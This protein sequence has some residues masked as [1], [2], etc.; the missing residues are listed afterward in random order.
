MN[1]QLANPAPPPPHYVGVVAGTRGPFNNPAMTVSP[2][3]RLQPLHPFTPGGASALYSSH[4]TPLIQGEPQPLLQP[5]HPLTPGE[6][7]PYTPATT[8]LYSRGSPSP[9]LQGEPQPFTPGGAPALIYSGG[10]PSPILQPQHPFTPGGSPALYSSHNTPLLQGEPQL[11]TAGGSSRSYSRGSPSPFS[12]G[13][14]ALYSKIARSL[15]TP[16]RDSTHPPREAQ[17][18]TPGDHQPYMYSRGSLSLYFG[19]SFSPLL[20]GEL[21]RFSPLLQGELPS[22]TQRKPQVFF[23][24]SPSP[25]TASAINSRLFGNPLLQ[26]VLQPSPLM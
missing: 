25:L 19:G 4:Y 13:A 12:R 5:Q 20:Y 8:P 21:Q 26:G 2:R 6:P 3:S 7:Q 16:G 15:P 10:S 11:Y 17:A 23:P 24:G 14:Q 18:L 22:F 9:V 1:K